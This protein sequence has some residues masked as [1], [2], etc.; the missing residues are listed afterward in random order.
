METNNFI[1][2][3]LINSENSI[4]LFNS[5]EEN[6]KADI[7]FQINMDT[8]INWVSEFWDN[9]SNKI[10]SIEQVKK[11]SSFLNW[12]I[13]LKLNR[14]PLALIPLKRRSTTLFVSR[15]Y[16]DITLDIYKKKF[17]RNNNMH[18][19]I[20]AVYLWYSSPNLRDEILNDY[21]IEVVYNVKYY[22]TY[23]FHT[24]LDD[25]F[26][27]METLKKYSSTKIPKILLRNTSVEDVK[28]ALLFGSSFYCCSNDC[29]HFP[30]LH[31]LD[32]IDHVCK[33]SHNI[34]LPDDDDLS[35][36]YE[37]E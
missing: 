21:G 20:E 17:R 16:R 35:T 10:L 19:R 29:D 36:D 1:K 31:L 6:V 24:F 12:S 27:N 4:N 37:T 9:F 23:T 8:E 11:Y 15:V 33:K 30:K 13:V 5:L 26:P 14:I 7:L 18:D 28:E 34:I 3:L 2:H 25:I 22:T 32:S